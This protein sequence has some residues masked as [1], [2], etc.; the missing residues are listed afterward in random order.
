MTASG[1]A[2]PLS[3]TATDSAPQDVSIARMRMGLTRLDGSLSHNQCSRA[4]IGQELDQHRVRDFPV[5]DHDALD[6]ALK[7][8]DAGLDLGDHAAGDRAVRDESADVVDPEF[9]DELPVLVEDPRNIGQKQEALGAERAGDGAGGRGGGG[10]VGLPRP[11][12]RHPRAPATAPA[13]VSALT[14]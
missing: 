8:V 1:S 9:L 3:T 11:A 10:G 7:R 6:A 5:Q 13:K 12:L 4:I 2:W 14:L